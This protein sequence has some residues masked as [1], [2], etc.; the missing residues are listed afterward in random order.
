MLIHE[1]DNPADVRWTTVQWGK[2]RGGQTL[3]LV[4]HR[5]LK[6]DRKAG[7]GADV[8]SVLVNHPVR[9]RINM[10]FGQKL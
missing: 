5:V 6:L 8:W 9:K 3:P 10:E 1:A 7:L 4:D 2:Y